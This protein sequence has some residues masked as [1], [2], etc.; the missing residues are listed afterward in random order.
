MRYSILVMLVVTAAC[1]L[2]F[3]CARVFPFGLFLGMMLMPV[4]T[5]ECEPAAPLRVVR[6]PRGQ[7]DR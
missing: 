7:I 2:A 3:Q 6:E 4:E 5:I 1:G